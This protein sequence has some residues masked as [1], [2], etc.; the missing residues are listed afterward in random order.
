MRTNGT[1]HQQTVDEALKAYQD[2]LVVYQQAQEDLIAA[3]LDPSVSNSEC[4][5]LASV[6]S[7]AA[8]EVARTKAAY[9]ALQKQKAVGHGR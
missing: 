5:R 2:A 4:A 6:V 1:S 7:T 3:R 9:E 8:R